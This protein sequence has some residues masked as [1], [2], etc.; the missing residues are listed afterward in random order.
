MLVRKLHNNLFKVLQRKIEL[1]MFDTIPPHLFHYKMDYSIHVDSTG[2][3]LSICILRSCGRWCDAFHSL[4]GKQCIRWHFISVFTVCQSA[5]LPVMGGPDSLPPREYHITIR[6]LRNTGIDHTW[7]AIGALGMIASQDS[8]VQPNMW[9]QKKHGSVHSSM[10]NEKNK[11]PQG[12]HP[13]LTHILPIFLCP[14]RNFGRHI[15]IALSIRQSVPLSCPV[16]ISYILWVRNSKFGVWIHLGMAECRVPFS[17]HCALT[18]DLVFRIILSGAYLILF[19]VGISILVCGC[20]LGWRSVSYHNWVTV[21]LN[22]TSDLVSRN[23]IE[24]GAYLLYS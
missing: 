13:V 4:L 17:G 6:L 19:E 22:L 3:V 10:L 23:Y 1:A 20:I 15:V 8:S 11:G 2:M 18:S 16:H 14:Q 7:K 5:C 12:N 9:W 24:S 21:T